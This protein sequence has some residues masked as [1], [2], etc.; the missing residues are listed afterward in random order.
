MLP[1][2]RLKSPGR[3]FKT[4]AGARF[5]RDSAA[6]PAVSA[7]CDAVFI[8]GNEKPRP[9]AIAAAFNSSFHSVC[10]QKWSKCTKMQCLS[11]K[12]GAFGAGC[13]V[14]MQCLSLEQGKNVSV[15]AEG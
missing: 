13:S 11:P 1:G 12:W 7:P 8:A 10:P 3:R 6:E 9:N 2:Y 15:L 4:G 14:R 5:C